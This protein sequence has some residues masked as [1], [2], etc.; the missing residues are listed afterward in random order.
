MC[1]RD[2]VTSYL[3]DYHGNIAGKT[4]KTG[5]MFNEMG[6]TMDYDAFGNQWI[7]DTPDPFGYCG[8]YY[9]SE[10]SLIYLRNRYYCL[11]YTSRCV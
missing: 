6:T 3:K 5:S 7:G 11:L 4:T 2:R 8:E 1:I 10:S 9:D